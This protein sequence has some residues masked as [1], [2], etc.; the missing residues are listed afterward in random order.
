LIAVVL[1]E[2]RRG[3]QVA[4]LNQRTKHIH[5]LGEAFENDPEH[6]ATEL[7]EAA[8]SVQ[9]ELQQ[10]RLR[11]HH[12]AGE[13]SAVEDVFRAIANTREAR[14]AAEIAHDASIARVGEMHEDLGESGDVST[15]R[16]GKVWSDI[17]G[18]YVPKI[19]MAKEQLKAKQEYKSLERETNK[20]NPG[21]I[22]RD[23]MRIAK[24]QMASGAEAAALEAEK[25]DEGSINVAE[26]HDASMELDSYVGLQ[27]HQLQ[28]VRDKESDILPKLQQAT[29]T[30]DSME[31]ELRTG[32][33]E[34][35]VLRKHASFMAMKSVATSDVELGQG[36][37]EDE[38]MAK[39]KLAT[40][41]ADALADKVDREDWENNRLTAAE[42]GRLVASVWK[43][44]HTMLA[45]EA[46]LNREKKR[47]QLKKMAYAV[48][49]KWGT[50]SLVDAFN[51][52]TQKWYKSKVV[53]RH[54]HRINVH[55]KDLGIDEWLPDSSKRLR[56][57]KD[58]VQVDPEMGESASVASKATEVAGTL[59]E[60]QIGLV[61]KGVTRE[62][63]D[64]RRVLKLAGNLAKAT[65]TLQRDIRHHIAHP[66][67]HIAVTPTGASEY[68]VPEAVP[69][70]QT[71]PTKTM[72]DLGIDDVGEGASATRFINQ[73]DHMSQPDLGESADMD[74]G[75]DLGESA[76]LGIHLNP[77][78]KDITVKKLA[79]GGK[80][81][82]AEIKY[83]AHMEEDAEVDAKNKMLKMTMADLEKSALQQEVIMRAK[84]AKLASQ[85][86]AFKKKVVTK[87]LKLK[88][89]DKKQLEKVEFASKSGVWHSVAGSVARDEATIKA[90]ARTV[91][92]DLQQ[93]E[94]FRAMVTR[95]AQNLAKQAARVRQLE[96]SATAMSTRLGE[97]VAPMSE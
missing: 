42:R 90:K 16:Q 76:D 85:D 64:Q 45:K 9:G 38:G 40:Q 62:A 87:L 30:I 67:K 29:V 74:D 1:E 60:A 81:S 47:Y 83:A 18:K 4:A 21:H 65:E 97:A 72:A 12:I 63:I 95:R 80:D 66:A 37:G 61:Q 57:P 71:G 17:K 53:G 75:P 15:A 84:V 11:A 96:K 78:R 5:D 68:F 86:S 58:A 59:S 26:R 52:E 33:E 49:S 20:L 79:A 34:E 25:E 13:A 23:A 10:D 91:D 46:Q 43:E 44:G 77:P 55:Y 31:K 8:Q 70:P 3:E 93:E 2:K 39:T 41:V 36:M 14:D 56:V 22:R 54:G 94:D 48:R 7:R 35:S 73:Q 89:K 82:Q 88:H 24:T 92:A 6:A 32:L 51:V 69:R 28:E 50:N 19:F 27:R